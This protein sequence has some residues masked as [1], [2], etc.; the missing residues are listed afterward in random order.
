MDA[1]WTL[2]KIP[3]KGTPD[4]AEFA[5]NLFEI[6]KA[7]KERLKKNDDWLANYSL[8]RG[9][10]LTGVR[11]VKK[12]SPE[13]LYFSNVERT[14][15]NIT[16]RNPTG[17]VVDLDGY[18]D[19]AENILSMKLKKWW[20]DTEQQPKTRHSA[21]TMEIYGVAPEKPVWDKVQGQPNTMP[22]DPFSFFPAPGNWDNISEEAP[23]ISF[24]YLDYVDKVEDEYGV[25]GILQDTAYELLGAVREEYKTTIQP[26]TG[27]YT[28][29]VIPA[30]RDTSD[31]KIER[32]LI[33]E[34]W[35]RDNSTKTEKE[36]NPIMDEDGIPLMDE[37]GEQLFEQITR[38]VPVYPDGVCTAGN[39][40]TENDGA[41]A[42]VL[43]TRERAKE[44]GVE[45]M[46]CFRSCAVAG[47]DPTLTY[48]AVPAS[49][50]KSLDKAGITIDEVDILRYRRHLQ[51]RH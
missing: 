23:Y 38:K 3:P 13:N 16:A 12:S 7:E 51:Y 14:V 20:K 4:V 5:Y 6:A 42:V 31:K 36:E 2:Q 19:D 26:K 11:Q 25:T 50:D 48:P 17:E 10:S 22:T 44:L 21:R 32:C 49:V 41:A 28:E 33:I 24:A 9:K 47:A 43:M 46:A 30:R 15:A 34:V 27:N 39:S 45:P 29:K 37:N 35:L 1:K 18:E 40:S 8:Y